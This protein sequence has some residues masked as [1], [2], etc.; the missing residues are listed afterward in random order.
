MG[1]KQNYFSQLQTAAKQK[2]E[3]SKHFS[4]MFL[5]ER[6]PMMVVMDFEYSS[7][8]QLKHYFLQLQ[9]AFYSVFVEEITKIWLCS[10]RKQRC[11]APHT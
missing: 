4:V 8:N 11:P 10:E 1:R 2:Q 9:L 3:T 6:N 5:S 7:F